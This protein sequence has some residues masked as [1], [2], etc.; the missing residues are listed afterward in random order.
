MN[1]ITVACIAITAL[2]LPPALHAQQSLHT[3]SFASADELKAFFRYDPQHAPLISAHRGGGGVGFPENSVVT[4]EHTL[5]HTPAIIEIDPRYTKDS[6]I[7]LLHDDTLTRMTTGSGRVADHTLAELQRLY[8]LDRTGKTTPFRVTTLDEAFEW[9]KG[10]TVLVLDQKG[11]P[12][13]ERAKL[14]AAHRAHAYAML[15]AYTLA[16]AK[17]VYAYDPDIVMEVFIPDRK[18][19]EA[20]L[21]SGIPTENLVAFVTQTEPK[22]PSIFEA[23]HQRGIRAMRGTSFALDRLYKAGKLN[24]G[25]LHKGYRDL[26]GSGAD[27]QETDL[28]IEAGHALVTD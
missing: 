15:I 12:A 25:Q 23:L 18:A 26:I 2:L 3:L 13:V 4:F 1:K 17:A 22:D 20:Y 21:S 5:R 14:I 7:V 28:P 8:L 16:D 9:A 11:I 6:A 10:K 27:I 24:R 19:L